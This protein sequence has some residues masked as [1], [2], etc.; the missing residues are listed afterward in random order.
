VRRTW[1]PRELT[2]FTE[3]LLSAGRARSRIKNWHIQK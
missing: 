2:K 3:R 1:S